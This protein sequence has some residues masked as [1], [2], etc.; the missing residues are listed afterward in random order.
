MDAWAS[1]AFRS[2]VIAAL[3]SV[4]DDGLAQTFNCD[5]PVPTLKDQMISESIARYPGNCPCPY[6]RDARGRRCGKRSAW[7]RPGGYLPLCFPADIT[8]D[9]VRDFCEVLKMRRQG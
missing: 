4:L 2:G 1:V 9:M 5:I 7:D 8:P 3:A 6:N